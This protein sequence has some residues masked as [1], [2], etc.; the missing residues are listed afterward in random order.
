MKNTGI[1][2]PV[3][4]LILA[5]IKKRIYSEDDLKSPEANSPIPPN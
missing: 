2:V 4:T 3:T 1:H 5:L